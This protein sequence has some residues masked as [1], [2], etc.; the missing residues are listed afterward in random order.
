MRP[1]LF[2][3]GALE[4]LAFLDYRLEFDGNLFVVAALKIGLLLL[5]ILYLPIAGLL[6]FHDLSVDLLGLLALRNVDLIFQ[7]LQ[8][9]L[10]SVFVN[11][12]HDI[13]REVQNSVEIPARNIQ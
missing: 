9:L 11:V 13:L 8:S 4:A 1:D 3:E 5:Q 2:L 10:A 6:D 12:S 7:A